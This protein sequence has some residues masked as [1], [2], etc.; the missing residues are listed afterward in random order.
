MVG[1][2]I[3]ADRREVAAP[4]VRAIDQEAAN[5]HRVHLGKRDLLRCRHFARK[6]EIIAALTAIERC[7][8]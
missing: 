1:P 7:A 5:A 8:G 2:S 4:V 3:T 6:P